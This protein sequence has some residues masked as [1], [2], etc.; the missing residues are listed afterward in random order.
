MKLSDLIR[1][2]RD[3][4]DM[5]Q[6]E[7]S[8]KCG[9]SNTYISFIEKE[10]NP[11]TGRPLIPTLEQYKKIADGMDITVQ[12][13]FERLDNDSP[14]DLCFEATQDNKRADPSIVIN[15]MEQFGHILQYMSKED[16]DFVIAAFD[17]TY[18]KMKEKGVQP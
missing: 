6:R 10:N 14:V 1:E 16:Y 4:M 17:R 9:L 13:L 8:R 12:E 3:R 7:F 11:K 18:K 2:Y 15:S 5:S